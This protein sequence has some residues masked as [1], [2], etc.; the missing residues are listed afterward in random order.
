M[1][2]FQGL[3]PGSVTN[4]N[5]KARQGTNLMFIKRFNKRAGAK[6]GVFIERKAKH[7][8]GLIGQGPASEQKANPEVDDKSL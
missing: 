6:G 1:V 7:D 2:M 3:A 4:K 8:P 5:T